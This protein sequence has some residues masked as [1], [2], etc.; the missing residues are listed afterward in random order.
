MTLKTQQFIAF[1][2]I[3]SFMSCFG[4]AAK[5][6]PATKD[7][8]A[9][10]VKK[11][12]EGNTDIDYTDFRHSFLASGEHNT[13]S[14]ETMKLKQEMYRAADEKQYPEVIKIGRKMLEIDYTNMYAHKYLQQS[15]KIL[16]DEA[17]FKKH[18]DIEFGLLRSVTGSGDGATCETGWHVIKVEEEYFVLEM[19]GVTIVKQS[20]AA[21]GKACDKMDVK[22]EA[23]KNKT[24]YFEISRVLEA[25]ADAKKN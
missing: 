4:Q 9:N 11:L 13:S 18:H 5:K 25:R 8:Y 23:G 17:N 1:F 19:M 3:I 14:A 24:Y 15:Y 16:G 7:T 20:I 10:Y 12:E 2:C 22:T 6:T 21:A